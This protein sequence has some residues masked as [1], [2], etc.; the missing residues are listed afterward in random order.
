M[1]IECALSL[2]LTVEILCTYLLHNQSAFHVVFHWFYVCVCVFPIYLS[3][4]TIITKSV[5]KQEQLFLGL[6]DE[7]QSRSHV[8]NGN[9]TSENFCKVHAL[10]LF[11]RTI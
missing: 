9:S 1:N 7:C 6:G 2:I 3:L 8:Q 11:Y 5:S 4:M 10:F